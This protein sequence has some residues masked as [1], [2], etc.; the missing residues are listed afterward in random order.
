MQMLMC[1]ILAQSYPIRVQLV[2]KL[3]RKLKDIIQKKTFVRK[4]G[5]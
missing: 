5:T 4:R 1:L 3:T 2:E